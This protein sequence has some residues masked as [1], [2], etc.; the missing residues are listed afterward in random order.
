[1]P[2]RNGLIMLNSKMIYAW[3]LTAGLTLLGCGDDSEATDDTGAG[4]TGS[5][6]TGAEGTES[7]AADSTS[8]AETG[9]GE[10]AADD[11]GVGE[12]A[13]DDTAGETAADDTGTVD[14]TAMIRVLHLGVNAPGVDVFANGE[15]P[16]ADNLM[17]REG[18]G[19]LEVPAGDYTFEISVSGTGADEAVL[20]PALTLDADTKYTAIAIGDLNEADPIGLQALPLVDDDAGIDA[21]NVRI[22]VVHAAPAVGEVDVWEIS[23][24]QNPAELLSDVPFGAAATLPDIPAGA[25]EIGLDLDNDAMPDVTFSVP[26]AGL[27]GLQVNVYAN[28]D[29][30]GD[31]A[32]IAQLPDG[33]VLPINPN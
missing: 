23:D 4:T 2:S 20:A 15:G 33:T 19:Y 10:T 32:L 26:D 9:A 24:P 16:V 28:N 8:V 31:V 11:T 6:T 18:T 14:E 22:T 25:L 5:V 21:A 7:T 13:A 12:T 17:F 30:N 29:A 27:G 3:G 1:M